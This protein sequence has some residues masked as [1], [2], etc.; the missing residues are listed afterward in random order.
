MIFLGTLHKEKLKY[1]HLIFEFGRYDRFNIYHNEGD[2]KLGFSTQKVRNAITRR[3][4]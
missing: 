4:K 3:V 1:L 2:K